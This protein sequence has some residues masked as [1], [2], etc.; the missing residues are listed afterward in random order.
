M[1]FALGVFKLKLLLPVI[2]GAFETGLALPAQFS[3]EYALAIWRT[4][5]YH[6]AR[7][8]LDF[9]GYTD[10]A[11]SAC[12]LLG[13]KIRHN[14]LQPYLAVTLAEFWRRWHITLGAFLRR[15][16]YLPRGGGQSSGPIWLVFALLGLWHGVTL[17]FLVWGLLHAAYFLLERS[18]LTPARQALAGRWPACARPAA[19]TQYALT[20]IFVTCSWVLFFMGAGA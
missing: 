6:Y 7:L 10:I 16:V 9:S 3:A 8:Y 11:V 2:R 15:H 17:T 13:L 20:Q 4:G 18:A 5:L 14:F 12:A 19:W 1:L